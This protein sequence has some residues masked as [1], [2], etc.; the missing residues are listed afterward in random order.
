MLKRLDQDHLHTK[1]EV[2]GLTV[3][4]IK[5]GPPQSPRTIVKKDRS[6]RGHHFEET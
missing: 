4:G 6:C 5:P 3:L 1:L 2:S